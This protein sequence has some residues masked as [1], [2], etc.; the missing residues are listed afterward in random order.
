MSKL[1]NVGAFDL[2]QVLEEQYM[3]EE[4]FTTFYEPKMDNSIS[5]VGVRCPGEINMFALQMFLDKY[6]DEEETARDFMRIKGVFNIKGSDEVFVMQC[7]H[8]LR[9][10]NFTR[11][12]GEHERRENR[13]IFIGRGMQQCRQEL[14]EGFSACVA[15]PLRFPVG[16]DVLAR[17]KDGYMNATIIKHWDELR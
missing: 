4:E 10:Q 3:D 15:K 17:H 6:L 14:T 12:W 13:I 1:F 7:V 9:N 11:P 2:T 16:S 8:M 5:N